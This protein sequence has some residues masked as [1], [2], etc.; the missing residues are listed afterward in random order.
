MCKSVTSKIGKKSNKA[1]VWRPY[2]A[3]IM[4]FYPVI[5]KQNHASSETDRKQWA[6]LEDTL[7]NFQILLCSKRL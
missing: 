3:L 6:L 2:I 1:E 7:I 5:E 4:R